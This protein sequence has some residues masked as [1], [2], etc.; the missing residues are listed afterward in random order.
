VGGLLIAGCAVLLAAAGPSSALLW[1][2]ILLFGVKVPLWLTGRWL[3]GPERDPRHLP[4]LLVAADALGFV[5]AIA[6]LSMA[7]IELVAS[8]VTPLG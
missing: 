6:M 1:G 2:S 7:V 3:S 8:N 5:A 4:E